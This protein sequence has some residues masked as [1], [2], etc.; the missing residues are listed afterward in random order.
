MSNGKDWTIINKVSTN[1]A[2]LHSM[3]YVPKY[4]HIVVLIRTICIIEIIHIRGLGIRYNS[5][6]APPPPPPPNLHF[7]PILLVLPHILFSLF[8]GLS[9]ISE[10]ILKNI[11]ASP[12]STK[13]QRKRSIAMN[14]YT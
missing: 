14:N 13:T 3:T 7:V 1:T 2:C 6:L 5:T 9:K 10:T 8:T 12:T 4:P 11:V